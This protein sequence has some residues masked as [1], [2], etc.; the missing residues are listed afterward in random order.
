MG[1]PVTVVDSGD[2]K[3]A[4]AT[5]Q[6]QSR[7]NND[8]ST[9]CSQIVDALYGVG[10][11]SFDARMGLWATINGSSDF[12]GI[13]SNFAARP[14]CQELLPEGGSGERWR[15]KTDEADKRPPHQ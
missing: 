6:K 7:T 5:T 11:S 10:L 4:T 14:Q 8:Y 9:L 2:G 3:P 1:D 12:V 13:R 15:F